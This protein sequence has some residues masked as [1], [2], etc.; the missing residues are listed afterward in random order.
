MTFLGS[1]NIETWAEA[2]GVHSAEVIVW[3]EFRIGDSHDLFAFS[4]EHSD[5]GAYGLV[6]IAVAYIGTKRYCPD[7]WPSEI[8]NA[9]GS[10]FAL[11]ARVIS[12]SGTRVSRAE[13][14][15]SRSN[16]RS[17]ATGWKVPM[18]SIAA[19]ALATRSGRV[20][21]NARTDRTLD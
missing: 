1:R 15:L 11:Y 14:I 20:D 6:R 2:A 16:S 8:A 21:R 18:C 3:A 9:I 13:L 10:E 7:S 12:R 4:L 17:P 19:G 5:A